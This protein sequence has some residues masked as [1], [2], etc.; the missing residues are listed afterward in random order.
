MKIAICKIGA[1]ITFSS[2][3]KSAANA[4]IL[5]F[6]RQLEIDDHDV[7][8]H[9][10]K[11]RNTFIPKRIGFE[12]IQETQSFDIY[13]KV[14]VFNGSINFFGGAPDP[15][16][17]ALYRAL[18]R[19]S[20]CPIIYVNTD[21]ALP[22]KQL[23]PIIR[24]R[25]WAQGMT[26]YEFDIEEMNVHYLTQGRNVAKMI[27]LVQ[28]KPE[29]IIPAGFNHYPLYQTILAKHEK[30]IKPN[31]QQFEFRPYDLGFGGY[32]RNTYKRKRI[33]HYYN[34]RHWNTLLFGNLRGVTAPN[35]KIMAKCSYQQFIKRMHYCRATVIVGDEFY[36]DNFFTLRMYESLLADNMVFIDERLD[37]D[38]DFYMGDDQFY[39]NTPKYMGIDTKNYLDWSS[40]KRR[41]LGDYDWEYQ[42]DYLVELLDEIG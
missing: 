42:R 5:Y 17:F 24:H 26:E 4:D 22:F 30:F 40:H 11:T 23:W 31:E 38:H 25:E 8:I 14:L 9:T 13:D 10:H 7:T 18:A 6:L 41:I 3:N 19:T 27:E 1:N 2:G 39:V 33:E 36:E 21:G 29:H 34:S 20:G 28:R 35:T 16:L 32:T 12:E 15:N 37:P